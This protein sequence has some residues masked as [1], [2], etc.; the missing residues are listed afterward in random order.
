[1]AFTY[2]KNTPR[3][4]N[5]KYRIYPKKRTSYCSLLKNSGQVANARDTDI[6]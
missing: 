5:Y 4:N 1:M 2:T 3:K 6:I